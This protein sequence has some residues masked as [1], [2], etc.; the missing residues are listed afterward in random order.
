MKL[1]DKSLKTN[2]FRISDL[3]IDNDL[4]QY[5]VAKKIGVTTDAYTEWERERR[6]IPLDSA[7]K[8]ANFY[9]VNFDY[10]FGLSNKKNKTVR[11]EIDY[12]LL[13]ERLKLLRKEKHLT[14]EALGKEIGLS[15]RACSHYEQGDNI[16]TS[17]IL[18]YFAQFFNVSMDY[19]TG[20]T[21][22]KM[23]QK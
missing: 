21:D 11:K 18:L 16:P 22:V 14:Q 2:R 20:R 10:L 4:K 17:L 9:N 7:N 8:L 19:L 23:I 1:K 13:S 3:R 15:Q 12:N 5:E 6:D